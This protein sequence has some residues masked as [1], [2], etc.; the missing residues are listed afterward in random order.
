MS[1]ARRKAMRSA[2]IAVMT[3]LRR[4]LLAGGRGR[5]LRTARAAAIVLSGGAVLIAY[6][7]TR[8]GY[9]N[10][11]AIG[12]TIGIFVS[13][14][15][16]AVLSAPQA[17]ISAL[18]RER[19]AGMLD[20]LVMAGIGP[21]RLALGRILSTF[22]NLLS[23]LLATLPALALLAFFGRPSARELLACAGIE[24][25]SWLALSAFAVAVSAWARST[26][27]AAALALGGLIAWST[28][29]G[30][31]AYKGVVISAGQLLFD[32]LGYAGSKS[33]GIHLVYYLSTHLAIALVGW[34]VATVGIRVGDR[35]AQPVR[36][37]SA[38]RP[39]PAPMAR[40]ARR[41]SWLQHLAR[42]PPPLRDAWPLTW[43]LLRRAAGTRPRV[44]A[45]LL[46]IPPLALT[47]KDEDGLLIALWSLAVVTLLMALLVP[48]L[49]VCGAR[50]RHQWESLL[51]TAIDGRRAVL[52][53]VRAA[54]TATVMPAAAC[55][56]AILLTGL[57]RKN[58]VD[59]ARCIAACVAWIATWLVAAL[60]G[61]AAGLI[62]RSSAG[63][64]RVAGWLVLLVTAGPLLA[65]ACA[66]LFKERALD[67][68]SWT[69]AAVVVVLA[70]VSIAGLTRLRAPNGGPA[71]LIFV[72]A[73]W[74][75]V[76]AP[77]FMIGDVDKGPFFVAGGLA[78]MTALSWQVEAPGFLSLPA[79]PML[80][81]LPH[82]LLAVML[83]VA[84]TR[85][86]DRWLGRPA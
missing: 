48:G 58:A 5:S 42:K 24:S 70:V 1:G 12:A 63:A 82:A 61:T 14:L 41:P 32:A 50:E 21:A 53:L 69:Y 8:A 13:L 73:T 52:D 4:D 81:A 59:V 64:V 19:E 74:A 28:L 36:G 68:Y 84:L 7:V 67:E 31:A 6:S 77:M 39:P 34:A 9:A 65:F 29:V 44:L 18:R 22:L 57:L 78:G 45:L 20:L 15:L 86:A 23:L 51:G 35:G 3:L 11:A 2:A 72:P 79:L 17:A 33:S 76:V 46:L 47:W 66:V 75:F 26:A 85:R 62:A 60:L 54:L 30:V 25:C 16:I 80:F 38:T 37:A 10:D 71:F 55:V 27:A 49:Q 43:L 83:L 40:P 56:L